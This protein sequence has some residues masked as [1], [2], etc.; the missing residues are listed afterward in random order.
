MTECAT[1]TSIDTSRWPEHL[2]VGD[3]SRVPV[4]SVPVHLALEAAGRRAPGA[5]AAT[6]HRCALDY[7]A[8]AELSRRFSGW[9]WERGLRP[10]D[11]VV[12]RA[13]SSVDFLALLH[14][15]LRLGVTLVPVHVQTRPYQLL[16]LIA[17]ADPALVLAFDAEIPD[18][19]GSGAKVVG[20]NQ[21]WGE[22]AHTPARAETDETVPAAP[23]FLL[24]TSGSSS[25]PKAVVCSHRQVNTALAAVA[26]QL[27][28]RADDVVFGRLPLA[29]DYGL[30]QILLCANAGAHLVLADHATNAELLPMMR[31]AGA[32]VL[33]VVPTLGRMAVALAR[34]GTQVNTLRLITNTGEALTRADQVG[35]RTAFPNAELAPM[36]GLTECKRVSIRPPTAVDLPTDSVGPPLP[37]TQVAILDEH[38]DPL[39]RNQTGQIV[40][41]GPHVADGYWRAPE[42]TRE[43]FATCVATGR[44]VLFTGDHGHLDEHGELVIGGRLD[45]VFKNSGV[46]VSGSEIEAAAADIPGVRAAALV[47]PPGKAGPL[48]WAEGEIEPAE[49]L[50]ELRLRLEPAKVPARCQVLPSL[51]TTANGKLDRKQ[52]LARASEESA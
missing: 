2:V 50:R 29:F 52:L 19:A 10:G 21:A 35:L 44:R 48:L 12:A 24:Y 33:P 9:L 6:D 18:L 45:D 40:V 15:A 51:P 25:Q 39:P 17:D 16:P 11:R 4:L 37:G 30:Y 31:D 34:R 28:Y 26:E 41:L 23:A 43:R 38:G 5:P 36:Y 14:G 22:A 7:A 27:R 49:V 47:R 1:S 46:R 8:L 13:E 42:P 20:I 3:P 32:T